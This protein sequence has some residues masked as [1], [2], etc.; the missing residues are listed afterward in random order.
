MKKFEERN[1]DDKEEFLR[2]G[3]S[4][5]N[6]IK[7]LGCWIG[8]TED[9]KQRKKRATGISRRSLYRKRPWNIK[10]VK[11]LQS[12]IDMCYRH[13][14]SNKSHHQQ[15]KLNVNMQDIRNI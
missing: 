14:K 12:W 10:E 5:S 1:N 15:C 8:R 6:E 7:M 9:I 13:L 2:F 4:V 11:T 3:K